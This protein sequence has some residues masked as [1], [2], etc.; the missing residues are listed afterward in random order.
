VK[1]IRLTLDE[2]LSQQLDDYIEKA[3]KRSRGRITRQGVIRDLLAGA[4]NRSE[5]LQR[6]RRSRMTK[7]GRCESCSKSG[8]LVYYRRLWRCDD[9]LN[10][11][12]PETERHVRET[13]PQSPSGWNV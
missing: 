2:E 9:C 1:T 5:E 7:V 13:G 8:E 12:D 4:I 11:E 3:I 10:D 6:V